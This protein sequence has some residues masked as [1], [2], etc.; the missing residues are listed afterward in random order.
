MI[1]VERP[2]REVVKLFNVEDTTFFQDISKAKAVSKAV[3]DEEVVTV[4]DIVEEVTVTNLCVYDVIEPPDMYLKQ[5]MFMNGVNYSGSE[6]CAQSNLVDG[7]TYASRYYEDKV[8]DD[9]E[10]ELFGGVGESYGDEDD[11][12]IFT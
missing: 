1:T 2:I 8:Q 7:R 5:M 4:R 9:E 12:M 6:S 11:M 10:S 3:L